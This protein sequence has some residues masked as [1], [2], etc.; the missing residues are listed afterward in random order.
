MKYTPLIVGMAS[1]MLVA[2]SGSSSDGPLSETAPAPAPPE[3]NQ[4]QVFIGGLVQKG[5]QGTELF[6]KNG[7]YASTQGLPIQTFNEGDAASTRGGFSTTNTQESGV[8]EADRIE[9][10]GN[11]LYL[12]QPPVWD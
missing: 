5:S 4:P 7:L 10:D 8:D 6:L 3:V 9:Y 11:Y 12:A 2:C 1:A